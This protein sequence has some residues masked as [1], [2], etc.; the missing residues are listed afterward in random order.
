MASEELLTKGIADIIFILMIFWAGL[1]LG[2]FF[3]DITREITNKDKYYF[4]WRFK[5]GQRR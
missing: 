4:W 2:Y 3:K 5:R 1:L